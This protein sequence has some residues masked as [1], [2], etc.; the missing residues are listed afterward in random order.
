MIN[1]GKREEISRL[2]ERMLELAAENKDLRYELESYRWQMDE[3]RK[4]EE[5]I[6]SLHQNT[7]KLKHDMR[8]HLMVVASYMNSGDYEDAGN[9]ISEILEKLN[10]V[11]S[12]VETGNQLLNHILN[13][14]FRIARDCGIDVKAEIGRASFSRM[15]GIDFSAVLNNALDNAIESAKTEEHREIVVKV[16]EKKGYDGFSVR[17]RLSASVLE[18]NPQLVST[19]KEKGAHGLGV[20]Q[21]KD[22]VESYEGLTDFYEEDGF[23]ILNV[24]IPK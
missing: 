11:Q 14:K 9:Y 7:R 22:I 18:K 2:R 4:Q 21:I 1:S 3:I 8:N 19:K 16:F 24:Y 23:F 15:K 13:E 6:R 5:E 10:A 17:N 12:Y 20:R